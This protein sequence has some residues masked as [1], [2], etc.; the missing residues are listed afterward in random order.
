[1]KIGNSGCMNCQLPVNLAGV[2]MRQ[3]FF[4][5]QE[6]FLHHQFFNDDTP[7]AISAACYSKFVAKTYDLKVRPN[8]VAKGM[9]VE[10]DAEGRVVAIVDSSGN[11]SRCNF[12]YIISL[13]DTA[14]RF[15]DSAGAIHPLD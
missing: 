4:M 2:F 5:C 3:E 1:M 12:R 8:A 10:A 15:I 14:N 11:T 6:F 7:I 13:C 9:Q